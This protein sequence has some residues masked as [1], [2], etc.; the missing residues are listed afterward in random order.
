MKTRDKI[1]HVQKQ[2]LKTETNSQPKS[3]PYEQNILSTKIKTL[4][5]ETDNQDK[6]KP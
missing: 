5:T 6:S 3:K 4:D 2:R 1:N